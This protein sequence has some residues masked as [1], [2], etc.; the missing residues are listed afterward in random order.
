MSS[1]CFF[2]VD[3]SNHLCSIVEGLLSLES[4]LSESRPT[5]LPVIPWQI[6]LVCLLTQTLG[7]VEKQDL[8]SLVI[9]KISNYY[10]SI[11][12]ININNLYLN[13]QNTI[14][15]LREDREIKQYSSS[16]PQDY[17]FS[18]CHEYIGN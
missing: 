1:T 12:L 5:W 17:I 18:T 4:S 11:L 10:N 13:Q 3:S 8:S 14:S 6:T 15:P 2:R 9:M 7:T 16:Q